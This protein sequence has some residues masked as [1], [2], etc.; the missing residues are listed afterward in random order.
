MADERNRS[1]DIEGMNPNR[2]SGDETR[3][4]DNERVRGGA[5]DEVRD[6]ADDDEDEFEDAD[7]LEKDEDEDDASF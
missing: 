2:E 1:G 4:M 7:D 5:I 3:D 6:I